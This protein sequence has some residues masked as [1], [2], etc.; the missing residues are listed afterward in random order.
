MPMASTNP[1]RERLLS[2]NPNT[3]MKKKV[4]TR[5]TGI[6]T[7]GMTAARQVLQEQ[8]YDEHDQDD[9]LPDGLDYSIHRLLMNSVGL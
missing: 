6:A 9:R 5:D 8:D 3:A 2:E 1:N 4:P 7:I